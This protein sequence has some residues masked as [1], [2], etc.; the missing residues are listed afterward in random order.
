MTEAKPG[1]LAER[2]LSLAPEL[3]KQLAKRGFVM[4]ATDAFYSNSAAPDPSAAPMAMKSRPS[5][6]MFA[7]A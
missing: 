7:K 2:N 5:K 6:M 3:G 1:K 4:D